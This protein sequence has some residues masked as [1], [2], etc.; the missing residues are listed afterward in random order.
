METITFITDNDQI[1]TLKTNEKDEF[2]STLDNF[3]KK[4]KLKIANMKKVAILCENKE[5][6][7]CRITNSSIEAIKFKILNM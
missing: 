3:L 5:S 1:F 6:M 4:H 2:L 7:S